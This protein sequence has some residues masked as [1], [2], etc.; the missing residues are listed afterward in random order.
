MISTYQ[1]LRTN[2]L[3]STNVKL[4]VGSNLFL[5]SFEATPE[6]GNHNAGYYPIS[7]QN[8]YGVD[9]AQFYKYCGISRDSIYSIYD[10]IDCQYPVM[11]YSNQ[12]EMFYNTGAS[13]YSS[14]QDDHQFE[15]LAPLWI[16][17]EIPNYFCVFRVPGAVHSFEDEIDIQS[18][19]IEK[20]QLVASFSMMQGTV[21]GDYLRRYANTLPHAPLKVRL[22]DQSIFVNGFSITTGSML[23]KRVPMNELL[24]DDTMMNFDNQ[25]TS[26]YKLNGLVCPFLINLSFLFDDE[27]S[28]DFEM[29]R[30]V[31]LYCD[32]IEDGEL[33]INELITK[34]I[35]DFQFDAVDLTMMSFKNKIIQNDLGIAL[36]SN[37]SLQQ[38]EASMHYLKDKNANLHS[39]SYEEEQMIRLHDEKMNVLDIAGMKSAY[40]FITATRLDES[41]EWQY[42][43][44]A[45]TL[46]LKDIPKNGDRL[47]ICDTALNPHKI[48]MDV[49]FTNNQPRMWEVNVNQGLLDIKKDIIR[50]INSSPYL[51]GHLHQNEIIIV[52]HYQGARYN[53]YF[54]GYHTNVID[55]HLYVINKDSNVSNMSYVLSNHDEPMNL[56]GDY[57]KG[58]SNVER[59]FLKIERELANDIEGMY[60][61]TND[62]YAKI[63]S[64]GPYICEPIK[65]AYGEI[66]RFKDIDDWCLITLENSDFIM[67]ATN[68]IA[69][70]EPFY[71]TYGRLSFY[72]VKDFDFD[73]FSKCYSTSNQLKDEIVHA[74]NISKST[75]EYSIE[76]DIEETESEYEVTFT[77]SGNGGGI[78]QFEFSDGI[79]TGSIMI[80]VNETLTED[81]RLYDQESLK[82][83]KS[84]LISEFEEN[85]EFSNEVVLSEIDTEYERLK[86]TNLVTSGTLSRVIPYINKWTIKNGRD[87]RERP[88]RLN[89]NP[90][91]DVNSFSPDPWCNENSIHRGF[92][93]EWPYIMDEIPSYVNAKD[94]YGFTN[95]SFD[96]CSKNCTIED[97]IAVEDYFKD[98]SID[99]F[100]ETFIRQSDKGIDYDVPIT[101]YSEFGEFDNNVETFFR[102]VH[103]RIKDYVVPLAQQ[104]MNHDSTVIVMTLMTNSA[105]TS[106]GA[107][108]FNVRSGYDGYK[109]SVAYVPFQ[110]IDHSNDRRIAVIKNDRFR[111][112]LMLVYVNLK[113]GYELN[114]GINLDSIDYAK[115]YSVRDFV[116]QNGNEYEYGDIK[117]TGRIISQSTP[118][119]SNKF[120]FNCY[121]ARLMDEIAPN[122]AGNTED[123]IIKNDFY[124]IRIVPIEVIDDNT[125]IGR[126]AQGNERVV[127]DIEFAHNLL[128]ECTWEIEHGGK[129]AYRA[130][131]MMSSFASIY[132]SINM[133][134]DN[135]IYSSNF[136]LEIAEPFETNHV[137][138]QKA[139]L[140]YAASDM[141]KGSTASMH[142]YDIIEDA[143]KIF[144]LHR[145]YGWYEPKMN[146]IM[147]FKNDNTIIKTD[148]SKFGMIENFCYH[149]YYEDRNTYDEW[150]NES[151]LSEQYY[152]NLSII[153]VDKTD[154]DI[155]ESNWSN[156]YYHRRHNSTII[157]IPGTVTMNEKPSFFGSKMIKL[158]NSI[159]IDDISPDT[160]ISNVENDQMNLSF[161]LDINTALTETVS[162]QIDDIFVNIDPINS[163]GSIETI[164]DDIEEYVKEN[165]IR[166]YDVYDIV[167]YVREKPI[168]GGTY[169][170][171]YMSQSNREKLKDG[172][173]VTRNFKIKASDAN[174][175]MTKHIIYSRLRRNTEIQIGISIIL[176]R[177]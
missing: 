146:D 169:D 19:V 7:G 94:N 133:E 97:L 4:V 162:N 106:P 122:I 158:P 171:S 100:T 67:T 86:E 51:E 36:K 61:R 116:K 64:V 88:Y 156:G 136:R 26:L 11:N 126:Y 145:Q 12:Y 49:V 90:A 85:S 68:Q 16:D 25:I 84:G 177:K 117:M 50:L 130:R 147:F 118:I 164:S 155:F 52:A 127:S 168:R 99:R 65:N 125:F 153:T 18:D 21:L 98:E 103:V 120:T 124:N 20:M 62:G 23:S 148:A 91:F 102:G 72:P 131:F 110:S 87:C 1:I 165:I 160:C 82:E 81:Q 71:P 80:Q 159:V 111:F 60:V 24:N 27:V 63:E 135:V 69:V 175:N 22:S 33:H 35:N 143:Q 13:Y 31:G 92:A 176:R 57:F 5:K 140:K 95:K 53:S 137:I 121:G 32:T 43:N 3:L 119:E 73:F 2:P 163:Y 44:S 172:L 89:F 174:Q 152:P 144:T 107:A 70:F 46:E 154:F 113:I 128:N 96:L 105:K 58:A 59:A 9:V 6:L 40:E 14:K 66:V 79:D 138:K 39:F 78:S 132:D 112:V 37:E 101:Q 75:N 114:D 41:F 141:I 129:G 34:Q 149:T 45:V 166:L 167:L 161:D 42:G 55:D 142:G 108:V 30:Y 48:I 157:G 115:M 109:F 8:M 56:T 29:N 47:Q 10:G 38:T 28:H 134:S 150:Y 83:M 54:L 76:Y 123:V 74:Q 170:F 93:F 77:V 139:E 151:N 173:N 104:Q 15:Y 17:K